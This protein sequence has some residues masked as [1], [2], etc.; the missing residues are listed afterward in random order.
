MY[1]VYISHI[2]WLFSYNC[3]REKCKKKEKKREI[4]I[5]NNK[6]IKNP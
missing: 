2:F 3:K 6:S 5:N 1:F 4:E